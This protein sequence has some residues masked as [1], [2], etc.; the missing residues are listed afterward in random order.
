MTA[1]HYAAEA[2]NAQACKRL[3]VC[4]DSLGIDASLPDGQGR[5]PQMLAEFA[6]EKARRVFFP[7]TSD[8]R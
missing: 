7:S 4:L 2:G 3:L 1:L 6:G 8:L 5:T